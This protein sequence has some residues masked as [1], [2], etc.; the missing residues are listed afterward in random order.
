MGRA[1]T[2]AR[3]LQDPPVA[4]ILG[5]Q[6]HRATF[7]CL[8]ENAAPALAEEF[9][10]AIADLQK[11]VPASEAIRTNLEAY[12]DTGQQAPDGLSVSK[13]LKNPEFRN[14]L[15]AYVDVV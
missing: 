4:P 13:H 8:T 10:V 5:R 9:G 7:R 11:D 14:L 12:R 6:P 1:S 15:F 3:I 2:P